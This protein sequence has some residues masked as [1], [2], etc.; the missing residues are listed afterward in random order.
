MQGQNDG[1]HEMSEEQREH[2]YGVQSTESGLPWMSN[3]EVGIALWKEQP[4]DT[5][6]QGIDGAGRVEKSGAE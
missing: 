2:V 3:A 4:A 5:N 6:I 1:V